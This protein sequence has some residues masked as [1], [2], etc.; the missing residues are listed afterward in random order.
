MSSPPFELQPAGDAFTGQR[1]SRLA[2]RALVRVAWRYLAHHPWQSVLMVLGIT[3]GV[4]VVVAIDLANASALRAFDL[5]TQAVAG[6]ATHQITGGPL[7]LDEVLYARLRREGMVEAAAPVIS[8]YVSSPQLDGSL[9]QLLGIDPFAEAPFRDYLGSDGIGDSGTQVAE[10]PSLEDLTRFLAQPGTVLIS[11]AVADR[12]SLEPGDTLSLD[13]GGKQTTVTIAGLLQPFDALSQRA[14][15]GLILADIATAQELTGR[16]GTI[17]RIDLILPE[18]EDG[19]GLEA[20]IRALLPQGVRLQAVAAR[21]GTLDEMTRAFRVNLTALSLLALMV[22]LFLIYNTMTFSVVQRRPLFGTLRALGAT[23][24]ETFGLVLSE[25]LLVGIVGAILGLGLGIILGQGA[26]RMVTRTINDLYFVLSVRGVQVPVE[27]LVKGGLIGVL[28]TALAA[29]PPAWEAAATPPRAVLMRSVVESK[30]RRAVRWAAVL[31]VVLILLG[32]IILL[33]PTNDLGI[34]FTGTFAVTIGFALLAPV[35]TALLMRLAHPLLG[36]LLGTL[37]RMAARNVINSLSRTSIA[38]AAL[39][40]AVSVTIGVS[41]MVSSFRHTVVLWLDQTLSGDIYIS[42]LGV[43]ASEPS[44]PIENEV[45]QVLQKWPGIEKVYTLRAVD[46]DSPLGQVHI[47]ASSNDHVSLER[48]YLALYQPLE[49]LPQAMRAGGVVVSEPFANRMGLAH[50]PTSITLYTDRGARDFPVLGIYYDYSSTQGS[51]L[52]A[53]PVYREH[54]DDHELTAIALIL[55][56]GLNVDEVTT[57]LKAEL[58]AAQ[59]LIIRPNRVLRQEVL[60]VFDR[61][62]TITGALQ[63][64]TTLVAF[65]GVLSAL[66]SLEL[67]RQREMGI[68]RAIGLTLRQMWGLILLETGLMG[69]AAGLL[70]LPTGYVLAVIL[71]YIINRRS[72]GWTLLMRVQPDPFLLALVV[73]VLAALLA[74][75]YP[76]LRIGRITSAEAMRYE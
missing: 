76:A 5:S 55:E 57:G 67:E 49:S 54:W 38:I 43:S 50:G 30:A 6:R 31:G 10:G 22:G 29:A 69:A 32:A 8:A 63:M 61:T 18:G 20:S 46:V 27:S 28:A 47:A 14:L 1:P 21:Q 3:L 68:L 13:L 71:I 36:R 72:F 45:L 41:L 40:V 73:S 23:R 2:W 12:A 26:V 7:G 37:G 70:A 34:S 19:A 15:D 66:L 39:M 60:E 58:P 62:F 11:S 35:V 42:A 9:M 16:S 51:V 64:L 65:V 17:E 59:Q 24:R 4:A 33:V 53:Q 48:D 44:T 75:I 56:P 25:A 74:G 52:M